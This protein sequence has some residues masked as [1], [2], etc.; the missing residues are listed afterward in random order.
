MI[1]FFLCDFL[2]GNIYAA[3]DRLV[4][5][6]F[7]PMD[8]YHIKREDGTLDG[9]DVE[10]LKAL[11]AY[12][13]WEIQY[14]ECDS[15]DEA[16]QLLA[17]KEVDLV[18]SAQYSAS[19]AEIYDYADLASGYTFGV[20]ATNADKEIAYEDFSAMRDITFGMVT[21]YVRE[22]E[23]RQYLADN[24]IFD[25]EVKEYETTAKLQEALD[26]GEVDAFVHTFTEVR[27]GQRLIGR[28]APMPFYY[29]SYQGNDDVMRELNQ[30]IA[31]LKINQPELETNLINEF[32]YNRFDKASLLTTDEKQYLNDTPT[33][34]VGYL[35]GH[36]PFSYE[37]NGEF[38]GLSRD[39]LEAGFSMTGVK[40]Q[41][42][43]FEE[44]S[45]A[46]AALK[47]GQVDMLAYCTESCTSLG[48]EQLSAV[49]D[50]AD[51]PLVLV[52]DKRRSNI[53]T[54]I[55]GTTS[56]LE[57]QAGSAVSLDKSHI[58]LYETQEECLEAVKDGTLDAALCDGYLTEHLFRTEF[59]YEN[60]QIKNVFSSDY[61][62]SVV[63]REEDYLLSSILSKTITTIDSKTVTEYMLKENTYPL[64]NVRTFI[65]NHSVE[66]I[67][68]L[69]IIVV[70]VT[71]AAHHIVKDEKKIRELMYKDPNMD[72]WNINYMIY[73]GNHDFL[74]SRKNE[75]AIVYLNLLQFRHYN[76]IYGWNAG[77]EVL[78]NI[79]DIL[80]EK[81]DIRSE[82]CAR[83]QGD[84]FV[85]LLHYKEPDD[86]RKR[87]LLLKFEIE[88]SIYKQTENR[89]PVQM[90]VY[91]IPQHM[92]DIKVAVT[93]AN[94]ALEFAGDTVEDTIKVYDSELEQTLHERHEQEKLLESARFDQDF[95]TYYQP[96]VDIRSGEIVGAEA[97]VRFKNPAENG[98]IKAP[99]FFVPYYERTG[100]ITEI[101]FFVYES[102]CRMLRRRLD[103]G[104]KVVPISCNFSRAHFIRPGFPEHFERVLDTYQIPKELIEVEITETLVVEQLQQSTVKQTIDSL[105][106]KSIRLSIDDF[107]SGYSSLGVFEQIP[108][109]VI[110]LDRSFLLNHN[111]HDRQVAIMKSVVKLA[112][113]LDAQ[114]VCEGVETADDISLMHEIGAY[115]AQGYYYSKPVPMEEFEKKLG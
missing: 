115:I 14:V 29:I 54:N 114:I 44:E 57:S 12:V 46:H 20:I 104:K 97:L 41:Y 15:W 31:D 70:A 63:V 4:K 50:Y 47:D 65:Q 6:A 86:L 17:D 101:D 49:R 78:Q 111:D 43:K 71:A 100:Q 103:A 105:Q 38:K 93:Y 26:A 75:Y 22:E 83:N 24:G 67:I 9:M 48:D 112:D 16:L 82:I 85:L 77:E 94:L 1:L 45:K 34:T 32:Y 95:V 40:L 88:T 60:L 68:I 96:K 51:I 90:G 81:V 69:L 58:R 10:Y 25:P 53:S 21:N 7:F 109:A 62:I 66:I 87:L 113:S 56:Y 106:E 39:M 52:V 110:K 64:A 108:A 102:V 27:E 91:F 2:Q 72:I 13:H 42:Q 55:V 61:S 59:Q 84:R 80:R 8:G 23:F 5:V 107:G 76:S 89:M 35:T 28:F 92:N 37:E 73:K 36:Y 11:S 99:G 18:G 79:R 19:R 33:L 30:A 3:E 98:S 74:P